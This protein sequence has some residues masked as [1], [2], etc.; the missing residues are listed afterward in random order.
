MKF[1]E[2]RGM[3]DDSMKTVVEVAD[4]EALVSLLQSRL[5]D[6]VTFKDEDL[7]IEPYVYD[8]RI[9]WDT[10]IVTIKGYGVAG[11]TNGTGPCSPVARRFQPRPWNEPHILLLTLIRHPKHDEE[12]VLMCQGKKVPREKYNLLTNKDTG[13]LHI[14]MKDA[15][16]GDCCQAHALFRLGRG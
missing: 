11:F 3:L 5:R 14:Y 16:W 1:R 9:G 8:K 15:T 7:K 2:H 10:Y 13:E 6:G 12:V 4:R